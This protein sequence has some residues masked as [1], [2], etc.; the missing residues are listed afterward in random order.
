[1]AAESGSDPP[2]VAVFVVT[3]NGNASLRRCLDSLRRLNY[4]R[5]QVFLIDNGSRRGSAD[6]ISSEFPEIN[7]L[8]LPA[9]LGYGGGC[10]AG[11]AW[12]RDKGLDYALL[13]NDDTTADPELLTALVDRAEKTEGPTV[14]APKI[15]ISQHPGIIWSAGGRLRWPW[16]KA[17]HI[18]VGDDQAQH[19]EPREVEWASGCALLVPI[20]VIDAI[21]PMDERY[22]LY[23]ED[24]E[25]CLRLRRHGVRVWYEPKA[26]LWHEVSASV[27][28]ID[29]RIVRYYTYRN[30]YLLAF[31]HGGLAGR[32]WF[33][34]HYAVTLLKIGVRTAF[35]PSYR[36]NS[37]YHARTR[38]MID[39]F[40]G[41][42]GKA[43]YSDE[44]VV[45]T[46]AAAV[47]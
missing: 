17:D 6:S 7:V 31:T 21:G 10:N 5:C 37:W 4:P 15:L 8:S 20:S 16:F 13:L 36:R 12:A 42:F 3:W 32:V 41:R 33:G 19:S 28:R 24:V 26:R 29:D 27:E 35:F 30:Y 43:P 22:F 40:R 14:V 1:M 46:Q 39:L 23:L 11:L 18:G 45:E 2:T 34:L 38:A 47:T 25:W 44:E 9:N